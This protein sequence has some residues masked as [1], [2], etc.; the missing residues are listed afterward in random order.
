M[1]DASNKKYFHLEQFDVVPGWINPMNPTL[2]HCDQGLSRGPSM[3]L[4]YLAFMGAISNTSY[5]RAYSD[6][7]QL[8]PSFAPNTGIREFMSEWW[9][10]LMDD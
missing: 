7:K 6:F 9:P 4:Y 2:I 10:A 8:Y 1:V 3:A 5:Y